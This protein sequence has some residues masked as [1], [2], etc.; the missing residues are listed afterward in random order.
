MTSDLQNTTKESQAIEVEVVEVDGITVTD[1]PQAAGESPPLR[2]GSDWHQWQGRVMK[3]DSRWWPLWVF[4]G[5]IVVALLMTFGV[6]IGLIF[7][8]YRMIRA[9]LEAI[10]R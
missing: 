7:V 9:I 10:F 5:I 3:L 2:T 6:V 4:L 8:I 1:R